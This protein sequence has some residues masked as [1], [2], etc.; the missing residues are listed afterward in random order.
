MILKKSCDFIQFSFQD[1]SR[2]CFRQ[3]SLFRRD[4][5]NFHVISQGGRSGTVV[6]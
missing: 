5:V 6:V 3:L 4:S 2:L 1:N